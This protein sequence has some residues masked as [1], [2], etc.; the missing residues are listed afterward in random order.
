MKLLPLSR[1][2]KS[3]LIFINVKK[4][5]QKLAGKC[6]GGRSGTFHR[7]CFSIVYVHCQHTNYPTNIVIFK[8]YS[9]FLIS[10][11]C[12]NMTY[13]PN[14]KFLPTYPIFCWKNQ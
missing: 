2:L 5:S 12:K 7:K 10:Q 9:C 3:L 13:F 6:K 1:Y 14:I 11:D 8:H 4:A